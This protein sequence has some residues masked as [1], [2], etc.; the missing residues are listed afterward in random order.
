MISS[1][2]KATADDNVKIAQMI[3]YI[4]DRFENM[5]EKEKKLVTSIFSFSFSGFESLVC[6]GR[7]NSGLY[8]KELIWTSPISVTL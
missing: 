7:R 3:D 2:F 8:G 1:K 4:Y 5:V 6:Y